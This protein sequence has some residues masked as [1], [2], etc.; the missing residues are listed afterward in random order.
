MFRWIAECAAH[1]KC[2]PTCKTKAALRDIRIVYAKR[3]LV[4]DKIEEERLNKIIEEER[5]KIE[6]KDTKIVELRSSLCTMKLEMAILREQY[7]D[8]ESKLALIQASGLLQSQTSSRRESIYKMSL[9]KNIEL[10]RQGGC[11]AMIYGKRIQT[12]IVSQ[13]SSAALFPGY[14]VRFISGF[15]LQPTVFFHVASKSIR[16]LSLDYDEQ[17]LAAATQ[18]KS[19]FIYSVTNHTPVASVTPSESP[20]WAISFDKVRQRCLHVGS[21]QGNTYVYDV[22]NCMSYLEQWSTPGDMSPVISITTIASAMDFP[23]GGFIVCKLQ[24]LWFYEYTNSQRTEQTKLTVEGPFVSIN[25]DEQT[26]I[27]LIATRPTPK[28][29]QSRYILGYLMKLDQ[30]TV[31]RVNCTVLGSN[32]APIMSR[33]TQIHMPNDNLV[34]A[35]LQDTKMLTIWNSKTASKTHSFNIDDC[36]LDMCSMNTNNQSSLLATLSESKCRIFQINLV[37]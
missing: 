18:D 2:C 6:E 29:P 5:I 35:Y 36:I 34:A 23:F 25:Y 1:T 10:N 33:S 8:L 9:D 30:T 20:I 14:G 3:V 13:K 12:L 4:A 17:L 15:N 31:F 7:S 26:K 16:D 28:H 21:A 11:R 32:S 19:A 22:R 27:L 37:N 24:S